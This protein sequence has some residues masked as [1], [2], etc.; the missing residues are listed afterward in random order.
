MRLLDQTADVVADD[1][2]KNL[3]HHRH[4]RLA[5]NVIA[6]LGLYH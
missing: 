5:A 1:F 4:V 3:V 2:A 6:E